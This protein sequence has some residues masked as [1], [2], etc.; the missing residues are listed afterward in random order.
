MSNTFEHLNPLIIPQTA[1]LPKPPTPE[2]ELE[3]F[4]KL[5]LADSKYPHIPESPKYIFFKEDIFSPIL[6]GVHHVNVTHLRIGTRKGEFQEK[7]TI[8][9]GTGII[10]H[11]ANGKK[12][13]LLVP[14]E[15]W[16]SREN[17]KFNR[18]FF[19]IRDSFYFYCSGLSR[20]SKMESYLFGTHWYP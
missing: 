13:K 19:L 14:V 4:K 9:I 15:I 3:E 17:I 6:P 7:A 16:V 12:S 18:E 5:I 11:P 8:L 1:P 2:E 10:F 20:F